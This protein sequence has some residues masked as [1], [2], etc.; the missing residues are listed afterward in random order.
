MNLEEMSAA[1]SKMDE[2][3]KEQELTNQELV[4]KVTSETVKN[5]IQKIINYE[6]AGIF[7]VFGVILYLIVSFT[8][9]NTTF[10]EISCVVSIILS[11]AL[12]FMSWVFVV[13]AKS[14]DLINTSLKEGALKI[15]NLRAY[16]VRYRA[17]GIVVVSIL[18]IF[19]IPVI[20]KLIHGLNLVEK[21]D[22]FVP[23]IIVGLVI[24]F[25]FHLFI[26]RKYR[27]NLDEAKDLV[28]DL[29]ND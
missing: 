21:L 28:Q 27:Q 11:A 4:L 1:W 25:A 5:R 26:L 16:F 18:M 7:L 20:V 8:K 6:Y 24:G 12:G 17:M 9:M 3:L 23:R 14:V 15:A 10:L 22:V 2:R 19:L 29:Q 13:K